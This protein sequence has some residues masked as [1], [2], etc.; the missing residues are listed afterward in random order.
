[1][2]R[3]FLL[4]ASL[5]SS[6]VQK[7]PEETYRYLVAGAFQSQMGAPGGVKEGR[8][9]PSYLPFTRALYQM[10]LTGR[11]CWDVLKF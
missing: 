4:H 3:S 5:V 1:M 9:A 6:E 2:N 11:Y 10:S 7:T 8:G